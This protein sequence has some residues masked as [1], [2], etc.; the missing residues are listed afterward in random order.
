MPAYLVRGDVLADLDHAA[1]LGEVAA[2]LLVLSAACA[3]IVQ[4]LGGALTLTAHQVDDT[5]VDLDSG[6][7]SLLLQ[8]LDEGSAIVVLLVESLVE[9][10]HA[11]DVFAHH[12]VSSE[13]Q[14]QQAIHKII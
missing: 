8:Q 6:N 5:L 10:D 3:E 4:T 9:Q 13:Q 1:P 7:D 14:L 12:V 2:V 11:A